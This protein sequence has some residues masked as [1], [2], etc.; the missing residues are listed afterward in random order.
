LP[1]AGDS[2]LLVVKSPQQ[3][4]L[5]EHEQVGRYTPIDPTILEVP[6]VAD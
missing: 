4:R 3:I 1:E 5:C 2:L 6:D